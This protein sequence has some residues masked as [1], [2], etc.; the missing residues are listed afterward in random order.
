MS[1][2]VRSYGWQ[3]TRLLHP[4]DSLG[5][6][7]GVGCHFLLQESVILSQI[8]QKQKDEYHMISLICGILKNGTNE[9]INKTEVESWMSKTNLWLP[10]EQMAQRDKLGDEHIYI[11]IHKIDN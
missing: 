9:L 7:T 3:P 8:S 11:T 2:S 5:K 10:G 4:Q 1:D 6:N